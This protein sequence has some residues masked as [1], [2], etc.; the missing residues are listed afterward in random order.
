MDVPTPYLINDNRKP[1]LFKKTTFSN[2]LKKEVFQTI[3]K[4]ID[5]GNVSDACLWS[6]ECIISGYLDELW[7][8]SLEYYCKYIN[9]NSPFLPY[10]FYRKL[11][12]FVRLQKD[13]HFSK[14]MMDLRNSQEVRNH[15]AE[16]MCL[17]THATKSR[18]SVPL[19]KIIKKDFENEHFQSKL[20][21]SEIYYVNQII[22]KKDPKEL[23]CIAHTFANLLQEKSYHLNQSIYWIFWILEWEKIM[24]LKF[25]HYSCFNRYTLINVDKKNGEDVIWIFWSIILKECENRTNELLSQQ[26]K[27]LFEFFKFKYTSSKKRKRIFFLINCIQLLDPHLDLNL[28]KYPIFENYPI[29]LQ[30]CTNIN[31]V[32]KYYKKEETVSKEYQNSKTKLEATYVITKHEDISQLD[33]LSKY[34]LKLREEKQKEKEYKQYLAK[35]KL[36]KRKN[37]EEKAAL[38]KHMLEKID[39]HIINTSHQRAVIPSNGKINFH[40]PKKMT[41][42]SSGKTIHILEKLDKKLKIKDETLPGINPNIKNEI[43]GKFKIIKTEST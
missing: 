2:F 3:I 39:N 10:H 38:K 33:D 21:E 23:N 26:V 42:S 30:A 32:Y 34:R 19:P 37:K 14:N 20:L 24:I 27:S 8:K 25:G 41:S 5:N 35:K 29:T 22:N 31:I 4:S 1:D 9:V 36:Q 6:T 11:V 28:S 13:P 15:I 40:T 18:K 43:P 16:L 17:L 7:N 12:L